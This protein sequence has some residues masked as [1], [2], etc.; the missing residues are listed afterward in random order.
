VPLR[1]KKISQPPGIRRALLIGLVVVLSAAGVLGSLSLL[2]HFEGFGTQPGATTPTP[3][4]GGTWT[5]ELLK[6]PSSLL[7]NAGDDA[8]G[9]NSV[10]E[11]DQ[12]LYLPL[13][14]GDAQG[15]IHP[16]AARE[17]PT[18]K[19]GGISA[20]ATTW[21]FHLR[22][23]L[24]WSD[25]QPYDAR[26]VDYTWRLWSDPAFV[27]AFPLTNGSVGYALIRSATVSADHLSIT[28]YL[29]QP[30]VPFLTCWVDG[31]QAPLPAHHFSMMTPAQIQNA[32]DNLNPTVT[33]GPFLMRESQPGDHY[34]L[35]RNPRYYLTNK[36]LPYLDRLVFH[37]GSAATILQ[38]IQAG[39]A[40]STPL[41][42]NLTDLPAYQHLSGSRLVTSPTSATFEAL[43]FNF[44]NAVLAT[45]LEVRDA[46]A[47]AI[48]HQA[49]IQG[50][51]HGYATPLCTDHPSALHPGYQPGAYCPAFGEAAA[52]K[53]L[54]DAGWVRGPDGV[55]AR[56]GERLEFEY[57][58]TANDG[59]W[60][61]AV[62]LLVQQD[63]LEIGIKLDIQN[64]P[65]H[66]FFYSILGPG[67]AS[68]PTGAVAG[69]FDIAEVA[70]GYGYDP[71]DSALLACDQTWPTGENFGSYCNPA[72]DALIQGE[73][74]AP[75]PGL[76]QNLF[77]QLHLIEVTEFPFIVLFSP[78]RVAAVHKGTHNDAPSPIGGETINVWEWW[79]DQGKC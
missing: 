28:F 69:R 64:Y 6:D 67:V 76:R 11:M 60:R 4:R 39:A 9:S 72:L 37:L 78:L 48:D 66:Q 71:D 46:I 35:A 3:V 15:V 58:T 74:A 26:D 18:L 52:N 49:L 27:G 42:P 41:T 10:I 12:A 17:I 7:P 34:T 20:D 14:Y 16:G 73:L 57:S 63:L 30:Y 44:H 65:N 61:N 53:I 56:D 25:G 19:N 23:G 47:R 59:D 51:L 5:A 45:H 8:V 32:P 40:D 29:T 36:G 79:C 43:F 1:S 33:S 75:D 22:R 2:T 68:P 31:V 62:Q 50:P 70:W 38:G 24:V 21:T 54:D 55:R 13:F 77:D